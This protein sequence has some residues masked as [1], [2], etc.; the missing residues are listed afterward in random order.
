MTINAVKIDAL[1]LALKIIGYF[2]RVFL[3]AA[4]F[5]ENNIKIHLLREA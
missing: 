2:F 4:D 3:H 5:I 1:N